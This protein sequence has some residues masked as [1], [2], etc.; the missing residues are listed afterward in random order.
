MTMR[1]SKLSLAFALSLLLPG[2]ALANGY[3]VPN[4]NPRDLAMAGSGVA[5]QGD[6]AATYA[7]PAALT[8]LE[9]LNVAAGLSV[10]NLSTDWTG[11]GYLAGQSASTKKDPVPPVS[12]FAAY[13]FKLADH[14]A[15]VG[16]GMNVP[17][18]GAV[19]WADDWA[20]RGR[21]ITVDRRVYGFYLT[22]GYEPVK[23]LR[24]GGGLVYYYGTEYLKQ[25]VQPDNSA[26]GELATKG[27][28]LSFDLAAEYKLSA[29]PLS[30]GADYKYRGKMSLSGNG[31]FVV[32]DGLLTANP[33]PVDQGVKHELTYPDVL[34]VGV[35]YQVTKPLLLSF[36]FTWNNYSLYQSDVFVGDKGTTIT[37]PRNYNDGYTFR[38]G[39]EYSLNPK[40]QLRG[41]ILRDISGLNTDYASATLPDSNAWAGA[42]GAGWKVM[43][44]LSLEGAFFYAWL[45]KVN[46]T[47][48]QE[49][50]GSY[51][52]D[53]WILSIGATWRTDLGGGK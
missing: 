4:V 46:V 38:L 6:A 52:T 28:A 19:K 11:G 48:T 29:I 43:P 9:G 15:G 37:V 12:V 47:G 40:L 26:Y 1:T 41:G 49:L 51:K 25:G 3:D 31:K 27:G 2:L 42:L 32:P 21:I 16:F 36:G 8:R 18:G 39:A 14:N 20:G 5:V 50:P 13:G 17:A 7:N 10:L 44:D 45:D 24:L 34:N 23:D 53:V 35:G 33:A 22:G 30:I